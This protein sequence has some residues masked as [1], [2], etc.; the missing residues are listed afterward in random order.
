[1]YMIDFTRTPAEA[2]IF[3]DTSADVATL[4]AQ[5]RAHANKRW[6]V[7]AG[8]RHLL[9][10]DAATFGNVRHLTPEGCWIEDPDVTNFFSARNAPGL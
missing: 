7:D 10:C 6:T 5:V 3:S 8:R 1:M 9:V 4:V 2:S